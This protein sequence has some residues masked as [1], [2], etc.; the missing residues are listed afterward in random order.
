MKWKLVIFSN[1]TEAPLLA[2][3]LRATLFNVYVDRPRPTR[4]VLYRNGPANGITRFYV[5]PEAAALTTE[6]LS[7]LNACDCDEP[8]LGTLVPLLLSPQS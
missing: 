3:D 4:A 2:S 8:D 7:I 5:A 1:A 6:Y